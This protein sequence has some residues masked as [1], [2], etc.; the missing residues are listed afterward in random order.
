MNPTTELI[1]GVRVHVYTVPT[2]GPESDGTLDWSNTTL[3]V[4]EVDAGEA[5]AE[6]CGGR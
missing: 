1:Q 6:G 4:A 5:W 2:D 3:V